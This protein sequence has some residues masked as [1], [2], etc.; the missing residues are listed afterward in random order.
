L[1]VI[2][3]PA[4]IKITATVDERDIPRIRVG[5]QALMSS[6]AYAG[7]IFPARVR[8]ITPGGDP[9]QRSFRVRLEPLSNDPL[10]VGMTLEVN[11]VTREKDGALLVPDGA[12]E[13]GHV[14]RVA[15]GRAKRTPVKTGIVGTDRTEVTEG[16][17][18]GD[19]ILASPP[20][21]LA[22]G[23]RVRSTVSAE[24]R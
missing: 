17:S 10:P 2:G 18:A 19:T 12:V 16:L 9:D 4:R 7:R 1:F 20:E 14:W 21:G 13:D 23:T 11:I 3:D 6:D 8:E 22:D 24:T 15:D 5:Q